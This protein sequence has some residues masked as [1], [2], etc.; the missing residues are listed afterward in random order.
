M[1]KP[2]VVLPGALIRIYINNKIYKEAQQV[3]YVLDAGEN[4]IYGI[5]SPFP[6]EISSTR[7]M[8]S[9]SITGVRVR[10]SGGL[11]AYNARPLT[12]DLMKAEY[13][14]IRIQDR[15]S[16][17]DILFIPNAK[18]SQQTFQAATKG[19]VRLSFNFKGLVAFES[20]DRA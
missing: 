5:D 19:L 3:Q 6:Q 14:S 12:I 8:V 4:E 9:G 20:L 13:I 16:G 18:I 17:E 10:S 15:A 7:S 1:S 2:S 11:Q